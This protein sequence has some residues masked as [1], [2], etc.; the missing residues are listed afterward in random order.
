[1]VKAL[2]PMARPFCDRQVRGLRDCANRE[3][4][5]CGSLL[6]PV[7]PAPVPLPV[8]RTSPLRSLDADRWRPRSPR[9]G[10]SQLQW[11]PLRPRTHSLG[12]RRR[13]A[14]PPTRAR[15]APRIRPLPGEAREPRYCHQVK[16]IQEQIHPT[17]TTQ[18]FYQL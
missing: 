18:A 4:G 6:H 15:C 12:A 1:M 2:T 16:S 11:R 10:H 9:N 8:V 13:C 3:G 14:P 17:K 7:P 5:I